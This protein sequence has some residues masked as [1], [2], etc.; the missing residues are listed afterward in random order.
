MLKYVF[1]HIFFTV[2]TS[3]GCRK[4]LIEML[5]GLKPDN[6]LSRSLYMTRVAAHAILKVHEE[7]AMNDALF[8]SL[9]IY[10]ESQQADWHI[11]QNVIANQ[12]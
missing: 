10:R 2:H 3:L 12:S 9:S 8:A 11:K 7:D 6:L 4:C 1:T 5:F